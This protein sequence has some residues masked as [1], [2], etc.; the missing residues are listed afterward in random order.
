MTFL[1]HVFA[2]FQGKSVEFTGFDPRDLLPGSLDYWTYP[3]SLTTPPLLESVT[4]IVL[5]EPIS[6]SS[7]QVRF[8]KT[9]EYSLQAEGLYLWTQTDLGFNPPPA[10][11]SCA[12]GA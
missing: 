3:G 8:L 4:W 1:T 7:G 5:R 6:G 9:A 11:S 2:L 10:A 12:T